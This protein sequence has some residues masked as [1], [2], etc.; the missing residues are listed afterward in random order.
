MPALTTNDFAKLFGTTKDEVTAKCGPI[1]KAL[2]FGH[3]KL[4]NKERDQLLIKTLKKIDYSELSVAGPH[5]KS[6][7]E[8]GWKE[9]LDDFIKSGFDLKSLVPKYHNKNLPVR[10]NRDFILPVSPDF[11]ASVTHVF[12]S[13]LFQKYFQDIDSIYEF[14]CGTAHNLAYLASLYPQKKLYGFDW[15]SSSQQI[16]QLLEKHFGYKIKGYNFD[17]FDPDRNIHIE[18][19]SAVFTFG[20]LEQIGSEYN[21]YLEFILERSPAICINVEGLNELYD[22]THLL[23]Y[24]AL[25]FHTKRNYLN[26]YLTQLRSLESQGKI[27]II[28]VHHQQFGFYDD[29]HSYVVWKPKLQN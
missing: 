3:R 17:F 11:V 10:L 12:R 14:G 27:E 2:D 6:D 16:I 19:T 18:N 21:K 28:K 23:D 7:W 5:R 1:I 8:D 26:S 25:K 29:P 22:S 4:T 13:W 24:L 9:N 20:A 15:A